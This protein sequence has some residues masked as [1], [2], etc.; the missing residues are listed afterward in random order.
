MKNGVARFLREILLLALSMLLAQTNAAF[1]HPSESKK[2]PELHEPAEIMKIMED[3]TLTYELGSGDDLSPAQIESPRVLSDQMLLLEEGGGYSLTYYSLP[4]DARALLE[5]AEN[6]YDAKDY[7]EALKRYAQL[8]EK[9]PAYWHVSVLIGDTYYAMGDYDKA[10]SAFK[11]AIKHNFADYQAHW[12]LGDTQ[13]RRGD[14][15]GAI[16]SLTTAHLLNVNH[17]TVREKLLSYRTKAGRPWKAWTYEPRYALKKEGNTI[18]VTFAKEWLGYAI[19]KAVW[20]FEP[21][22]AHD[23]VGPDYEK[24]VITMPEEKEALIATIAT[25]HELKHIEKIIDDGYADEFIYYELLARKA[26]DAIVL[27]PREMF[28]R[29]VDYVDTHH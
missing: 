13:W 15:T 12:F 24:N 1:A 6:A 16:R 27:F 20:A 26:P 3:S 23:M 9:Q 28:D 25:N 18:K 11:E 10:Q 19:V 14:Q 7:E 22:Y 4:E 17:K 5:S 2:T 8:K 21:G 29:L